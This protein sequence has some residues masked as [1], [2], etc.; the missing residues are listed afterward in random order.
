MYQG[1]YRKDGRAGNGLRE[2]TC[3]SGGYPGK[4]Q[5]QK[6]TGRAGRRGPGKEKE[7][8]HQ[9]KLLTLPVIT[10]PM[11]ITAR[12]MMKILRI[13]RNTRARQRYL[14]ILLET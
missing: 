12:L 11:R 4:G 7:E 9:M 1:V 2:S 6:G 10:V 5:H 8:T 13:A 14:K 3:R